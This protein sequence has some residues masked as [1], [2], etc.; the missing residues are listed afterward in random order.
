MMKSRYL[1]YLTLLV[2]PLLLGAC[3]LRGQPEAVMVEY[4]AAPMEGVMVESE[5]MSFEDAARTTNLQPI[6]PLG[7]DRLVIRNA[8]LNLVVVD[9]AETAERISQIAEELGG[10]V[11]SMNIFQTSFGEGVSANQG[12][13]SIR[14]PADQLNEALES[15]KAEAVE[16][17]MESIS[18]QDVTQEYTDL[19]SQLKNLEAAEE[20]LREIMGS[21]T[22]AEDV[23]RVYEQLVRVREQI[24]VIKGRIQYLEGSSRLS[25]INVQLT[26]DIAA[27]PL[28][29]GRWQPEGTV[30]AAVEA[31]LATLQ[32]I[33]QALIWIVILILPIVAIIA[34]VVWIVSWIIRK[35]SSRKSKDTKSSA[36]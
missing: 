34:F 24:E 29:I 19:Q 10:F 30:K 25:L 12:N 31:L 35:L 6:E 32:F 18:G 8:D 15:I 13:I 27:R 1:I 14:V 36:E 9:P 33:V 5:V 3:A 11:V 28:Q 16:I 4:A 22:K 26:P 7:Q 17:R 21:L 2:A 23:L 20:E